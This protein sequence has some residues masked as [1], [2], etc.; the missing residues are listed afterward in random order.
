MKDYIVRVLD[1]S[2]ETIKSIREHSR[3]TW[4]SDERNYLIV[5][6]SDQGIAVIGNLPQVAHIEED[7]CHDHEK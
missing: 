6:A 1:M 5:E 3:I 4:I 2:N 7:K